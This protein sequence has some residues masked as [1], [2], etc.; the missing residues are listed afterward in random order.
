MEQI[1]VL[2]GPDRV[3]RRPAVVFGSDDLR[4]AEN[5]VRPLLDLFCKEA[6]LGHCGKLTVIHSGAEVTISGDDRGLCLGNGLWKQVFCEI[7]TAPRFDPDEPIPLFTLPETCHRVLFGDLGQEHIPVFGFLDLC[8]LQYVCSFMD[9]HTVRD[10]VE[11]M[12]HFEKGWPVGDLQTRPTDAPSGTCI[13]FA[14]DSEVF[15]DVI[16][17]DDFFAQV[18]KQIARRAPG[19]VCT[20][21]DW[22]SGIS[23]T[24]RNPT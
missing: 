20:W 17:S 16:L 3:R 15:S 4:G 13:R 1:T 14:L 12:L 23:R 5:A 22:E 24:Y 18:L 21:L 10:G 8:A 11:Q 6:M 2:R 7:P 9:I 19:L